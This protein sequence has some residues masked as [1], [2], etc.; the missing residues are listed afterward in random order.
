MICKSA[1]E[2]LNS[3]FDGD[4][5]AFAAEA[6]EHVRECDGCREWYASTMRAL[7]LMRSSPEPPVPDI[8][9][10]VA[11][12]LPA[13]HPASV[14]RQSWLL[15]W[16]GVCWAAGAV[17]VILALIAV[18][19]RLSIGSVVRAYDSAR[20]IAGAFGGLATAGRAVAEVAGHVLGGLGGA[21]A[22]LG[23]VLLTFVVIDLAGLAIILLVWR[24]RPRITSACLI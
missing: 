12:R 5:H 20:T 1:Q 17:V 11:R 15:A 9:A 21:V 10:M 7:D 24:R 14:A 3:I 18:L 6:R 2:I 13:V 8:A 22:G 4:E 16:L 23:P 19:Q